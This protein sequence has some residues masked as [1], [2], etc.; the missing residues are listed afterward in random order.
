MAATNVGNG[1]GSGGNMERVL[2]LMAEKSASDVY[3]SANTPILIKI[4]GQILQLSDQPL[5]VAQPRQLLAELLTPNQLED[6]D[7]IEALCEA[8]TA[9]VPIDLII[10]GFCCLRPGIPGQTENVRI[11]SVIGRFLEHSRIFFFRNGFENALEGEFYIGSADWMYRN[12]L[13]RV[14]AVVPV[15]ERSLREKLWDIFQ[16]MTADNRQAWDMQSDGTY[17]Q[18]R[19]AE[20][21]PE[22]GTHQTLM[23]LTRQRSVGPA[24]QRV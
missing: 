20:G 3:L 18:R 16:V 9:G 13:E 11:I 1:A 2:R 17:I 6:L 5:S 22:R 4:N 8:S 7:M 10:R 15:E 14:E 23:A 24:S 19:P 12:L 21:T